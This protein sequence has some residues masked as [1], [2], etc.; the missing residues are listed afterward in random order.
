MN[1]SKQ[2]TVICNSTFTDIIIAE[3]GVIGFDNFQE[4]SEGFIANSN[5]QIQLNEVGE[6]IDRYKSQCPISYKVAEVAQKNW[7]KLW[8]ESYTPIVIADKCIVRASFHPP[9][10][11]YQFEIIITPKMSFGTGHHET[12]YLMMEAQLNIDNKNK[13]VLDAGSGTGILSILSGKLGAKH[14]TAYDNDRWVINA[15][16]ENFKINNI[17]G[18]ITLG[19]VQSIDWQQKYDIILANIN[20]NILLAD[21]QYYAGLLTPGG[22][23]FLSGFY[24]SDLPEIEQ[25]ALDSS[26]KLA[27]SKVKNDWTIAQFLPI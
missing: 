25:C 3:F 19:T 23:L 27:F 11:A 4:T 5:N 17:E 10:P 14:I 16:Q 2:F 26:L 18:E 21:I 12:T 22:S 9:Q 1:Q 6:I 20:K 8:E 24:Q 13:A 7:N 15:I